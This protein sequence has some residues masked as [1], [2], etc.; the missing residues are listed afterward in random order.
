MQHART[1]F[2]EMP[3][4][5]VNRMRIH[6]AMKFRISLRVRNFTADNPVNV[7]CG[8]GSVHRI[9]EDEQDVHVRQPPLLI[10]CGPCKSGNRAKDFALRQILEQLVAQASCYLLPVRVRCHCNEEIQASLF[11]CNGH[12]VLIFLLHLALASNEGGGQNDRL[13]CP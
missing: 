5:F 9:L 3:A 11:A 13:A 4:R 6:Q 7:I 8:P 2:V 1:L 12:G 10:F